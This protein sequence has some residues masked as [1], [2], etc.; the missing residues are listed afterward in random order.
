METKPKRDPLICERCR[1]PEALAVAY[2]LPTGQFV[3]PACSAHLRR[4][5]LQR[6]E[7][8]AGHRGALRAPRDQD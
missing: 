4:E 2:D 1:N 3:C 6:G 8:G 7:R 5:R